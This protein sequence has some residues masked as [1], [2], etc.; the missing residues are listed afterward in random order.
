MD[1]ERNSGVTEARFALTLLICLLVAIGYIV[2]LRLGNS[3]ESMVEVRPEPIP[4]VTP[5]SPSA[6][7][8]PQV[9]KLSNSPPHGN[10]DQGAE[11]PLR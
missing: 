10:A 7:E 1:D 11:F 9:L 5:I 8:Q 6:V 2:L 3:G 4:Q